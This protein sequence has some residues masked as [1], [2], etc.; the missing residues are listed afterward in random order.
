VFGRVKGQEDMKKILKGMRLPELER[1]I[2]GLGEPKYRAEQLYLGLYRE[3]YESFDEFNNLPKSLRVK[4]SEVAEIPSL[5]IRKKIVSRDGTCKFTF[6]LGEGKEIESVWIPTGDLERKTICISSQVGCTLSCAFCATGTLL[7]FKG[8]LKTWQIVDQVLQVEKA[9]GDKCTN[10]VF[11]GMGE[12]MHNYS[13]VLQAAHIFHEEKG[14][15][16]GAKRIT[17]S[18]AGVIPGLDR[19]IEDREPFNIAISLNHPNPDIRKHIMNIDQK[20]PLEDLLK[21]ARKFTKTLGRKVTFEYIMIPSINMGQENANRLIK[22]ARSVNCKINLI[23]LNTDFNGWRRPTEDEVEEF[24]T[25]LNPAKVP[26]MNRRS[27][28]KDIHG[29]CGMLALRG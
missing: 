11:M 15:G 26:V 3:R 14:L 23:P 27:P 28:G 9:V 7:D 20:Y 5:N 4:L 12:P 29:A 19:F 17:I 25:L 6:D 8:N 21:T 24:R 2:E 16:L 1:F 18:T 10:I 13:A 22:I